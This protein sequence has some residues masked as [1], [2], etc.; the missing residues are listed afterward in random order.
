V[1]L[2]IRPDYQASKVRASIVID[3]DGDT[4]AKEIASMS[5]ALADNV[6]A[7]FDAWKDFLNE[8]LHLMVEQGGGE[9]TS[10]QEFKGHELN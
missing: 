5:M 3:I 7:A 2:I 6:P 4:Q 9:I 1:K 8:T 10:V